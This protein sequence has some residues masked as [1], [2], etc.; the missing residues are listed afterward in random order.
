MSSVHRTVIGN[1]RLSIEGPT[2]K[3]SLQFPGQDLIDIGSI[4]VMRFDSL[5]FPSASM[6]VA[7]KV[8]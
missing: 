5:I 3:A 8:R 6:T 1:V 4:I 2:A 7:V